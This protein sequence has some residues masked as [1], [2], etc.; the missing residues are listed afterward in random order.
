M[1]NG[2]YS[3]A[4]G[5]PN[6]GWERYHPLTPDASYVAVYDYQLLRRGR[7]AARGSS[8]RGG[9][10]GGEEGGEVTIPVSGCL[11]KKTGYEVRV[12]SNL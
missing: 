2:P 10:G 3:F 9:R 12:V 7:R 8:I 11:G 6:R 1:K 5:T 4:E